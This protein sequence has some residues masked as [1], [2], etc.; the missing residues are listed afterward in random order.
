MRF[1]FAEIFFGNDFFDGLTHRRN[2]NVRAAA[3]LDGLIN[4]ERLEHAHIVI[5]A[6]AGIQASN[7]FFKRKFETW[8]PAFAGVTTWAFISDS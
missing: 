4:E 1:D 5:P 6:K 7:L 3:S 8:T 2:G